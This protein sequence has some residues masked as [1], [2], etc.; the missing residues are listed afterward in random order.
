[1]YIF[2]SLI[3]LHNTINNLNGFENMKR[4]DVDLASGLQAFEAKHFTRAMQ[5]LSPLA[6]E[7]NLEAQHRCA[8]MYQNGL[9]NK[10][11]PLLAFKWMKKAA[12]SGHPLA[13]HGLGFMYMEGDCTEQNGE[14]AVK[15]F[16]KAADQ[17][18]TG[19]LTTLALMYEEGKIV[20]KD[21]VKAKEYLKRAGF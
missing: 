12:E 15:W 20:E 9:G 13:Q 2:F 18:L 16:S 3:Y 6:E 5:L 21:P 8:I 17:G 7:G 1:M 10:E 14:L 4:I 19:S 11:N